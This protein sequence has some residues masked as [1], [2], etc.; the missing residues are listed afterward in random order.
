M[1]ST[2]FSSLRNNFC[3]KFRTHSSMSSKLSAVAQL[4][5][6]RLLSGADDYVWFSHV[7]E[8]LPTAWK[9]LHGLYLSNTA[10]P[11][12]GYLRSR[13]LAM[14]QKNAI[15]EDDLSFIFS[16]GQPLVFEACPAGLVPKLIEVGSLSKLNNGANSRS[17]FCRIT[18]LPGWKLNENFAAGLSY[19]F[20]RT[21]DLVRV[22]MQEKFLSDIPRAQRG[23]DV[24]P[25]HCALT[26]R[27]HRQNRSV[28]ATL[29]RS[30]S[31]YCVPSRGN[32]P[33]A[34]PTEHCMVSR[35]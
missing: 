12:E 22:E 18:S 14:I 31:L 24:P 19:R 33:D 11:P 34:L 8:K 7:Y 1:L 28:V 10:E 27:L 15:S 3:S 4:D 16:H 5:V 9:V 2:H 17:S 20:H 23:T 13:E 35:D 32:R 26:V 25:S 30:L 29:R 6:L 21:C